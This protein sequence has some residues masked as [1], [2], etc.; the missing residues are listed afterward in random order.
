MTR[1]IGMQIQGVEVLEHRRHQDERG[2]FGRIFDTLWGEA[3]EFRVKQINLSLS[4]SKGTLRGMHYQIGQAQEAKVITC[5]A[6]RVFDVVADLR[7]DSVTYLK[8]CALEL[9][10]GDG[11]GLLIPRGCAHG[12]LTLEDDSKLLYLHDNFHD[13]S[14]E[15]GVNFADPSL[16]IEWPASINVVSSRDRNLPMISNTFEGL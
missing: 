16:N 15:Q 10:E 11:Q 3:S 2:S 8:W 13:P 9:S 7:K 12:F 14:L 1:L 5:L 6:G 4:V